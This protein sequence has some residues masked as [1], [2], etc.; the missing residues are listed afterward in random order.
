MKTQIK[1]LVAFS[2]CMNIFC[3]AFSQGKSNQSPT[4]PQEAIMTIVQTDQENK[5]VVRRLYETVFN[6]GNFN[7]LKELISEEFTG[8][9]GQ[10]GS[11]Q[12]E[13]Q[14]KALRN[15]FPDIKWTIEELVAEGDKVVARSS[16]KGTHTG[17]FRTYAITRKAITNTAMALYQLKNGKI[18]KI[19]LETDRLGFLQA[20]DVVP[21]NIVSPPAQR[22]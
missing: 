5:A 1:S 9:N 20:I 4:K 12:L 17:P 3:N 19:W 6:T 15:G 14:I 2:I 8:A 13:E 16:W 7:L 21:D 18:V 11:A 22:N 10:K